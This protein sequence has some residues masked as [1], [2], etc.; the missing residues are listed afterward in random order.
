MIYLHQ[1]G[2]RSGK[3]RWLNRL[4]K[5]NPGMYIT[6]NPDFDANIESYHLCIKM[7]T[8]IPRDLPI[9]IDEVSLNPSIDYEDIILFD[10]RG[11]NIYMTGLYLLQDPKSLILASYLK[12]HYPE[13][14]I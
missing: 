8:H 10:R 2:R 7:P 14:I 11:Y 9:Y 6:P 13:H 5:E 4:Y 3:T 12:K 1:G